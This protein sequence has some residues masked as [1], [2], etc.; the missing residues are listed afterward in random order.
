MPGSVQYGYLKRAVEML[1]VSL[2]YERPP[3]LDAGALESRIRQ[4][5]PHTKLVSDR[6]KPSPLLFAH[7][8]EAHV[9]EYNDGKRAPAQTAAIF[10]YEFKKEVPDYAPEL[11]QTWDWPGAEAAVEGCKPY[12]TLT[13]TMARLL[14]ARTRLQLFQTV[15]LAFVEA[16]RPRAILWAP[17]CKFL[18]PAAFLR[19]TGDEDPNALTFT[20]LN[21]RMFRVENHN[22]GDTVMDTCGLAAFGLPDL[23][24][25]FN[26]L[27]PQHV[28]RHLFNTALYVFQNGN[29]IEDGHTIDGVEPGQKWLCR[30]ELAVVGPE[31]EVIDMNPGPPHAAGARH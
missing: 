25:H 9:I 19:A 13:E 22:P 16:T 8:A 14:D 2:F 3:R 17:A 29:V 24:V 12:V 1:A 27:D 26:G 28:A 18:D 15:L 10:S 5:L 21:V 4:A 7:E 31:R 20:A 23:Q 6:Q 30:H 11:G